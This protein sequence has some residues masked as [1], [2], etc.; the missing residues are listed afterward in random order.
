MLVLYFIV[1]LKQS[2]W[3]IILL[4][5]KDLK[6]GAKKLAISTKMVEMKSAD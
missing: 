6:A 4:I 2:V 3:M 1:L 5:Y